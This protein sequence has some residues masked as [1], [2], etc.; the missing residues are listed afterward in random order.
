MPSVTSIERLAKA[1]GLAEGGEEGCHV[2]REEASA[3][4]SL[5]ILTQRAV[6]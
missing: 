5:R 4:I 2:D 6:R 1:E 3:E